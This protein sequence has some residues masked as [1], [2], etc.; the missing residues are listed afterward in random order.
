VLGISAKFISQK[1]TFK[2]LEEVLAKHFYGDEK[3]KMTT[4]ISKYYPG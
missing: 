2:L 1:E 4:K 3:V